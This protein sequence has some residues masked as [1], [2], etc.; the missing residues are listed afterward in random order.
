[1][2]I[3]TKIF[4]S[5]KKVVPIAT[6]P[7][8]YVRSGSCQSLEQFKRAYLQ[9]AFVCTLPNGRKLAYF[10]SSH[11]P[12]MYPLTDEGNFNEEFTAWF[13]SQARSMTPIEDPVIKHGIRIEHISL[14]IGR[15][16]IILRPSESEG[17]IDQALGFLFI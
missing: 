7:L 5:N 15:S 3:F 6:S 8:R 10:V 9:T 11:I 13:K 2:S 1:M 14:F 12:N 16:G 17:I 4:K